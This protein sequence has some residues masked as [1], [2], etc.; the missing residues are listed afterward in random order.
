MADDNRLKEH[1]WFTA[2]TL[3]VNAFLLTRAG[4]VSAWTMVIVSTAVSLFA[5]YLVLERS[6][7]T[8]R[9]GLLAQLRFVMIDEL[10]GSLFYLLLILISWVA[11]VCS[12]I[13]PLR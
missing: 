1:H 8:E 5:G 10:S 11:V 9:R 4:A 7:G 6:Q 12:S 13:W 3:G 2:T